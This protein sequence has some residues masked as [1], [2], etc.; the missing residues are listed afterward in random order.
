MWV[1]VETQSSS[2]S[3]LSPPSIL[4]A[5][6]NLTLEYLGFLLFYPTLSF[7][8]TI[9]QGTSL[10]RAYS[11]LWLLAVL[12][13]RQFLL[14]WMKKDVKIIQVNYFWSKS[15]S[16]WENSEC[17]WELDD[18]EAHVNIVQTFTVFCP[19]TLAWNRAFLSVSYLYFY[20][21]L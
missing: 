21:S 15:L 4:L 1:S 16:L 14:P 8:N 5:A 3:F 12:N 13:G 9:L 20:C 11:Y 7:S 10:K 6:S 19:K 17:Q 18:T 2:W